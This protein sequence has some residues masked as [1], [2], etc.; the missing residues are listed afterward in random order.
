MMCRVGG[1]AGRHLMSVGGQPSLAQTESLAN[2]R[3][4]DV[5]GLAAGVAGQPV[6]VCGGVFG[7]FYRLSGRD[8]F[9][10]VLVEIHGPS[11]W[12]YRVQ[13]RRC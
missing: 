3:Q 9:A 1:E 4:R 7:V 2:R 12:P 11:L 5:A 10:E 13:L 8:G 6:G